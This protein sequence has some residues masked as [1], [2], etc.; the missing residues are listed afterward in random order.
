MLPSMHELPRRAPKRKTSAKIGARHPARRWLVA[1]AAAALTGCYMPGAQRHAE[2][3]IAADGSYS[4]NGQAVAA[5]ELSARIA[6]AR[7][8]G[9]DLVVQVEASANADLAAVRRA[10]EAVKSAHARVAFAA[11]AS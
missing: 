8:Q 3:R 7:Q 5:S 4:F 9:A 10:V 11:E 2:L 1:L 6:A